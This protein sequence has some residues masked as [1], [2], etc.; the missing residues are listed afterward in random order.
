MLSASCGG[1]G[2]GGGD[3][4]D[5]NNPGPYTISGTASYDAVPVQ[6]DGVGLDYDQI[7]RKPIRG[8]TIE[9]LDAAGNA[10]AT[11][12]TGADGT[13]SVTLPSSQPVTVRVRAELRRGGAA[14]GEAV[15]TVRDN[16]DE[17]ALYTLASEDVTPTD[18]TTID[19][20]AASGWDG[21]AYTETRAAAPFAILDV[22]YAAQAKVASAAPDAALPAVKLF[23]SPQNAPSDGEVDYSQGLIGTSSYVGGEDPAVYILGADGIDTDEYDVHVVAHELGHYLQDAVS[24]DDSIGGGHSAGQKLDM[25]VAFSEGFGNAW[26]GMALNDPRYADSLDAGQQGGFT[27]S[28]AEAPVATATTSPG[29]Y[30]EDTVQYLLWLAHQNA[31]IG[32]KPIYDSLVALREAPT[33]TSLFS[34]TEALRLA[35]PAAV[36]DINAAW[37]AQGV[38]GTDAFGTGEANNGGLSINLPIYKP[39]AVP[40]GTSQIFCLT[41]SNGEYNK[42]GNTVF[43]RFAIASAGDHTVTVE[44]SVATSAATDPDFALVRAD[45]SVQRA[46]SETAN[47]E[48]LATTLSAGTHVLAL[49]DFLLVENG[50][51]CFDLKVD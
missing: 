49:T 41:G 4:D 45:G 8:A 27:F 10:L 13:Y 38:T 43:V 5:E 29:W 26:S 20:R 28:V 16:T 37:T 21:S 40:L 46:Q 18:D 32:F 42:L 30:A 1:G 31:A 33:F 12:V 19:L 15:F 44:R 7:A 35:V 48:T 17:E 2:G 3:G 34:F 25:R 50:S 51:S 11:A 39:Y 36:P 14:D 23:W 9:L 24:R 22:A 47:V 6:A